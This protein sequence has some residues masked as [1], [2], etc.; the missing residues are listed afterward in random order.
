M[1]SRVE[2][3]AVTVPSGTLPTAPQ[4]TALPM[5]IGMVDEI[6]VVIPPG[7]SG[8]VGFAIMCG[9]APILPREDGRWII[10]DDEKIDWP[11]SVDHTAGD[12]AIVAYNVGAFDHTLYLRFLVSEVTRAPSP[13]DTPLTIVQP[14][15]EAPEPEDIDM[16]EV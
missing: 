15:Q 1:A 11:L 6:E 3:F 13:A 14:D 12:W 2:P 5:D 9:G 4:I 10:T 7:P 16:D 8:L